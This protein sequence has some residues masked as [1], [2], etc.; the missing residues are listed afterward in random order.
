MTGGSSQEQDSGGLENRKS[1]PQTLTPT[2]HR[3]RNLPDN[4]LPS[5]APNLQAPPGKRYVFGIGFPGLC[6]L[7]VIKSFHVSKSPSPEF[8]FNNCVAVHPSDFPKELDHVLV[9]GYP[10]TVWYVNGLIH[11]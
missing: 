8:P 2:R 5:L 9:N 10:L 4:A 6:K 7:N 11:S 3:A 1:Q